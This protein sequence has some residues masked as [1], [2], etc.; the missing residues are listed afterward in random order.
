MK[1]YYMFIASLCVLCSTNALQSFT[2]KNKTGKS[3][4]IVLER[5]G[6]K[7]LNVINKLDHRKTTEPEFEY[8]K[9]GKKTGKIKRII[10]FPATA[11]IPIV[12]FE[13][14]NLPKA[15]GTTIGI[16]ANTDYIIKQVKN[17][18]NKQKFI[19]Y[20]APKKRQKN[21]AFTN[22]YKV[23]IDDHGESSFDHKPSMTVQRRKK[24]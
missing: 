21:S 16:P 1:T 17:N 24:K 12:S 5:T 14:H 8:M 22:Y 19:L 10:I 2:L 23:N 9:D 13:K 11:K 18:K 15:G 3:I 4:T 7:M 20:G 6:K